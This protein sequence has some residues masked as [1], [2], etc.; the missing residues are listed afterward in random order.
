MNRLLR[1]SGFVALSLLTLAATASAECAWVLW[2]VAVQRQT[3]QTL[4]FP[5]RS[6]DTRQA[7]EQVMFAWAAEHQA[8]KPESRISFV[9]VPDTVD[10]RGPKG[11]RWPTLTPASGTP[12]SAS[13]ASCA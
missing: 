8:E 2:N 5:T 9:C 10:P 6:F 3:G 1:S 4:G 13:T 12:G 11:K 7:C